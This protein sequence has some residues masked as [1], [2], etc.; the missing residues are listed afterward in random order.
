VH[1]ILIKHKGMRNIILLCGFNL[2]LTYEFLCVEYRWK[3]SQI[4]IHITGEGAKWWRKYT[5]PMFS[6][7]G[8]DVKGVLQPRLGCRWKM[9]HFWWIWTYC[10]AHT[11]R[12]EPSQNKHMRQNDWWFRTNLLLVCY[13]WDHAAMCVQAE[14][15]VLGGPKW[16]FWWLAHP[17]G[18]FITTIDP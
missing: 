14:T 2:G 18:T 7:Y 1:H 13:V 15:P 16:P 12:D 3:Q 10:I 5:S 11:Q 4:I 9:A 17:P 6:I 8:R